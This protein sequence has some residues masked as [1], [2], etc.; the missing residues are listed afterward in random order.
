MPL[1]RSTFVHVFPIQG[2]IQLLQ[3]N[4]LITPYLSFRGLSSPFSPNSP[5]HTHQHRW[6]K[7]YRT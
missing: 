5:I 3:V 4:L 1:V 2:Q 6:V 7:P